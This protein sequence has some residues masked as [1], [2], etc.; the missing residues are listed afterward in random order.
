MM[1]NKMSMSWHEGCLINHKISFEKAR[2]E[3]VSHIHQFK[4]FKRRYLADLAQ[5]NLAVKRGIDGYDSDKFGK[6]R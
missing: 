1:G 2:K 5:Y 6:K 3:L 4:E